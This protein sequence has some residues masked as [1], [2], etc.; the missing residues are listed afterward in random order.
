MSIN[1]L[2]WQK[3]WANIA[4]S[5]TKN[6]TENGTYDVKKYAFADV[7]VDDS[8]TVD[9]IPVPDLFETICFLDT[10]TSTDTIAIGHLYFEDNKI[11][12]CEG[13]NIIAPYGW[14]MRVY[15]ADNDIESGELTRE[16]SSSFIQLE[17]KY[18]TELE[19]HYVE[20]EIPYEKFYNYYVY[21]TFS[22]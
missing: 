6:I 19:W 7:N 18:D 13:K 8:I 16:S 3:C 17:V 10:S 11:C 4:P 9:G 15:G 21:L 20:F 1:N 14:V 5:G 22:E 2:T 12:E